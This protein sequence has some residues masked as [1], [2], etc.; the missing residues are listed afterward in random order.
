MK[1]SNTGPFSSWRWF[2]LKEGDLRIGAVIADV[3][4]Q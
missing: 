4:V 2:H 1:K 3:A